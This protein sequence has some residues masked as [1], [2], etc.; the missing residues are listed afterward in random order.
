[1]H[2]S[3][4]LGIQI[5]DTNDNV[6]SFPAGPASVN[7]TILDRAVIGLTPS[8]AGSRPAANTVAEWT[9][10][11]ATDTNVVS[12]SDGTNWHFVS[13]DSAGPPVGAL[14]DHLGTTDP[15]DADGVVRWLVLN[16]RSL[17][18]ATYPV[19]FSLIG[20][21]YGSADG[22]HFTLPNLGG[23]TTIGAGAGA[24]AAAKSVG[25][26]G[27]EENHQLTE[28]ELAGHTHTYYMSPGGEAIAL[29]SSGYKGVVPS[30]PGGPQ[31]GVTGGDVAHNNMQP[32]FATNKI[33]RAL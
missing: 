23:R 16:G 33:V 20:T 32:Y 17:L 21:A 1:M 14:A 28:S 30:F 13:A 25:N 2:T 8:N 7:A 6:T 10:H 9:F 3:T 15:V 29:G 11:R 31:T 12:V 24:L 27:G 19:L 18:R 5:P 26:T 22:S 4:R